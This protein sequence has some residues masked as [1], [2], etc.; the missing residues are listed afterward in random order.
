MYHR[1]VGLV[2][3]TF[4]GLI[5][6]YDSIEFKLVWDSST[7][8]GPKKERLTVTTF[9]Y[10]SKA[11]LIAVGGVDG[12]LGLYDPS[13]KI[14]TQHAKAHQG[15]VMDV[16]FYDKQMQLISVGVD[17]TIMLWDSLKLECVQVIKDPSP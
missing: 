9:D 11:G 17:R 6:V 7:S 12:K 14:L 2:V 1:D 16:Y 13:A 4:K 8:A 5:H 3:A 10:S 15:E